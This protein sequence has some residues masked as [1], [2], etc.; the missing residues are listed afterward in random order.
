MTMTMTTT[1]TMTMTMTTTLPSQLGAAKE[2]GVK[3]TYSGYGAEQGKAGLREKIASKL[4]NDKIKVSTFSQP[5]SSPLLPTAPNSFQL[6]PNPF[7][8]R[9]SCS[10]PLLLSLNPHHFSIEF[11]F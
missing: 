5:H 2:L 4:Y 9:W 11:Q 8:Q 3:E 6:L 7:P 10:C 1:M